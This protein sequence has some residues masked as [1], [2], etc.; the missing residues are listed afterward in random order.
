VIRHSLGRTRV[1]PVIKAVRR[2]SLTYLPEN[3]LRELHDQ[4]KRLE[5][6]R[7]HGVLIEAGCALGGSAIVMAAAKKGS[8]PL[9][10]YDV[11]G[12]IPAPSSRDGEDVHL[13]YEVIRSGKSAGIGG[14]TYYGY[15]ADLE[16][17]V[18]GNFRRHGFPLQENNVHLVK[19]LFEETLD[20]QG[21]VALA[22]IDADWYESVSTCLGRIAPRLVPGGVL[23]I[24]DYNDW[25]GCRTAVDEYFSDKHDAYEF[26]WKTRLHIVRKSPMP[27]EEP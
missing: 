27:L 1:F 26:V 15:E 9:F 10:V 20:V 24:D 21:S 17:K 5:R 13:R 19:G 22:H 16:K 8:R 6:E 25:S 18:A 3:A 12:M 11:F 4:V 7:A 2:D 14:G 23:V